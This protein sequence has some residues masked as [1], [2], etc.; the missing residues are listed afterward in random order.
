ALVQDQARTFADLA[1]QPAL[2]GHGRDDLVAAL[3]QWVL[4]GQVRPTLPAPLPPSHPVIAAT[5]R[6]LLAEAFA[7]GDRDGALL[8]SPCYGSAFWFD[9]TQAL[10]LAVLADP[11][12]GEAGATLA[13]L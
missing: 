11:A 9:K 5:N 13:E 6:A 8:L 12:A 4:S 7:A 2:A 10:A 1:A 3:T